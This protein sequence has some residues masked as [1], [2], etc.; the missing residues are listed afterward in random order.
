MDLIK[1]AYRSEK[2]S[3]KYP[4]IFSLRMARGSQGLHHFTK[5]KRGDRKLEPYP[6]PEP[7]KRF[8]DKAIYGVG[9]IGPIMTIPQ[10]ALVFGHKSA[11]GLSV[12]TW[13]TYTILSL[14]WLMYGI[15]HKEKPII[16]SNILWILANGLVALGA[17]IYG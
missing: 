4:Q 9:V 17:F 12:I 3:V 13:V 10:I 16:I 6:H 1:I 11:E 7:F 15:V 14:F 5:R 8:L 2:G